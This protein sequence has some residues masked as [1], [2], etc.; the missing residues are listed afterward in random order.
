MLIHP[1]DNLEAHSL[2]GFSGS[3]FSKSIYRLL[4]YEDLEDNIH[5]YFGDEGAHDKWTAEDY[6]NGIC[7]SEEKE[8]DNETGN[9]DY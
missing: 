3:F 1:A 6:E 4:Q 9:D 8:K 7:S 5:S 2:G